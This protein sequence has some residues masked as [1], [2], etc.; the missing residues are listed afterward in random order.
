MPYRPKDIYRGRRKFRV[1]LNILLFVLAFLTLGS[2]TMFYVL[3]R[4]MVYDAD[5]ATLRL[6]FTQQEE[7]TVDASVPT[8]RP[9]FEPVQVQVIWEDPD[10]ED[11]NVGGW[12]ELEPIK[13]WFIPQNTVLNQNDLTAAIATVRDGNYTTAILEMKDR[14]G[15]LAWPSTCSVALDYYTAGLTDVT[16]AIEE[17]HA[18]GKT[19]AAQISCFCDNLL[20]QRNW[21]TALQKASGGLYT[22]ENGNLWLDPY[23]H[24]VRAYLTDMARELA[25]MGFDEIILADLSHP[26]S[27][28]GFTYSVVL[29]TEP[30]PIVAV[31]QAG[32]RVAEALAG[33]ETAVSVRLNTNSLRLGQAAQTGQDVSVFWKLFARVYCPTTLD[34]IDSDR[35]T[36]A[37]TMEDGS[38]D[39]RFVP[40][41]AYTPENEPSYVISS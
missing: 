11:V 1:P 4:Y 24:T 5:G 40:V 8:A 3:Q 41:L 19:V 20:V 10:F 9:T 30:D 6:P 18:A 35:Q 14:A 34:M 12:E 25:A 22:D 17:L 26:I 31:C 38:T 36:A 2:V 23:N 33:T 21:A 28:L 37:A 13:G 16:W 29:Q 15:Q 39:V 27:D 7:E 32:R